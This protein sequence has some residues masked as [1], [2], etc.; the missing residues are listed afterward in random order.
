M[1]GVE[2]V[3]EEAL[4]ISDGV[5]QLLVGRANRGSQNGID[6]F[7]AELLFA[8]LGQEVGHMH[9]Q[10]VITGFDAGSHG[11]S[12]FGESNLN[13][14]FG[15]VGGWCT[16][17]PVEH[18]DKMELSRCIGVA[19]EVLE[20]APG[21]WRNGARPAG[22]PKQLEQIAESRGLRARIQF[23]VTQ[24]LPELN[25][26]FR[27]TGGALGGGNRVRQIPELEVG[28]VGIGRT[29]LDK[30][31]QRL[32]GLGGSE[33]QTST[34]EFYL[35]QKASRFRECV[36]IGGDKINV[37]SAFQYELLSCS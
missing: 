4:E 16:G 2:A 11:V 20:P 29:M 18:T 17:A 35:F 34:A 32:K 25:A 28:Q 8:R 9:N 19:Q 26:G 22:M 13:Q 14:M 12:P 24:P 37:F 31:Q 15:V 33:R 27:Q 6:V 5:E 1:Y 3:C 30:G 23:P 7:G 10:P 36:R 21:L